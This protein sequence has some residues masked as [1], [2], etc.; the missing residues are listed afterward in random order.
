MLHELDSALF[1]NLAAA[2]DVSG[3]LATLNPQQG[4]ND[5]VLLAKIA[6]LLK[7]LDSH[8]EYS[9]VII[10]EGHQPR[11]VLKAFEDVA[12]NETYEELIATPGAAL[13]I[14]VLGFFALG[15]DTGTTITL[16]S[17]IGAGS[18]VQAGPTMDN[19]ANGGEVLPYC[20]HGWLPDLPLNAALGCATSNHA[21]TGVVVLYCLVPN[22][23]KDENGLV[24]FDENGVPQTT[25]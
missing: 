17:K 1:R 25:E 3:Q 14:R 4:D 12:A 7:R 23:A 18:A 22:Y 2:G 20:K 10:D 11:A 16:Y 9:G 8:T 13:R 19:A 15:G 5:K 21:A 6:A 24:L